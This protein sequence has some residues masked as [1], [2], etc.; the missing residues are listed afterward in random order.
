V[1]RSTV[2]FKALGN[3]NY[4]D[5][6]QL[7]LY[8]GQENDESMS[9]GTSVESLFAEAGIV[10]GD[11]VVRSLEEASEFQRQ[12]AANRRAYLAAETRR[13]RDR[14]VAR[15]AEQST[16]A[17]EQTEDLQILHSRGA[18]EDFSALQ[19]KLAEAQV[20]VAQAKEEI[21]T[22]RDLSRSKSHLRADELDLIS[23]TQLD[24]QERLGLRA[25]IMARFSEIME[26]LY[27]ETA[28]LIVSP[29]KSG[30]QFKVV[31]PRTGSG[32]VH[33]MSILALDIA[34]TEDLAAQDRGPGFLIHD[35]AIFADVDERQRA[36]AIEIAAGSAESLG[37][38]HL[39]YHLPY[40]GRVA[41]CS[42]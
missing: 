42:H 39:I 17:A 9:R 38:Q 19:R 28:D 11:S 23:R 4:A 29:G 22:L 35:S 8:E 2:R 30:V 25:A 16:I 40:F 32:G 36:K 13:I 12:V 6:Q 20:Q 21:H 27:G 34:V 14:I 31:L 5:R 1:Q 7:A 26:S 18:L 3:E 33:L 37:Y 10:L 15:E 41:H 24:V